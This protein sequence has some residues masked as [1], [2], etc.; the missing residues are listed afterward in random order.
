MALPFIVDWGSR[1][2]NTSSP[3]LSLQKRRIPMEILGRTVVAISY[4]SILFLEG[5]LQG[6][7]LNW[8]ILF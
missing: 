6:L 4:I 7:L 2:G 3:V 1:G 5:Y 8:P